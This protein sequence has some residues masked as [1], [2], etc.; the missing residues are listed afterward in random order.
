MEIR[1]YIANAD[2]IVLISS[3][4]QEV[5]IPNEDRELSKIRFERGTDKSDIRVY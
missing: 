4:G 1:E 3:E 5:T 2:R